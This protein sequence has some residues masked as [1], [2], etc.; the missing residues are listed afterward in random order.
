MAPSGIGVGA[1]AARL[2]VARKTVSKIVNERGA[3]TVDMALRLSRVFG[4]TPQLWMNL[5]V[6]Y[7]L[8]RAMNDPDA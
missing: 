8:F 3:L 5:Q 6:N 2:G 7:D 4:T 1:L